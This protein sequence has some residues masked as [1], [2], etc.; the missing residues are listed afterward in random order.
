MPNAAVVAAALTDHS[1]HPFALWVGGVDWIKQPGVA[2][3]L[4]GVPLDSIEVT[5]NGPGGVSS[6]RCSVEDPLNVL[7]LPTKSAPLV[8]G[9][10]ESPLMVLFPLSVLVPLPAV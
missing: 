4:F 8:S 3:N 5:E 1:A 2:G 10:P 7:P 9:S 6:L